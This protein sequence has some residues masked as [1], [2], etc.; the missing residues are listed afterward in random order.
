MI[1]EQVYITYLLSQVFYWFY[2]SLSY[3]LIHNDLQHKQNTPILWCVR[4]T[5]CRGKN[6][7]DSLE[8]QG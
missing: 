4:L 5:Y 2:A 8:S 7:Y 1:G 6:E 3:Q